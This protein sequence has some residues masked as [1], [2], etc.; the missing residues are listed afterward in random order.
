MSFLKAF[1]SPLKEFLFGQP[2]QKIKK[3][4]SHH[5]SKKSTTPK[6]VR[7][8][9]RLKVER[10]SRKILK[11]R[12]IKRKKDK[13][14]LL[15][16][17]QKE[18]KQEPPRIK[19]IL[20]GEITHYFSRIQVVVMKIKQGKLKLGDKLHIKGKVTDFS[21]DVKSM[22]IESVDVKEARKGQLIGLKV[23]KEAKVGD[24][25]FKV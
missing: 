13:R 23:N 3:Q 20:V 16:T 22:Q 19:E 5:R 18:R 24:H 25:V 11:S 4:K 12:L 14:A 8:K 21:Q 7:K 2:K 6:I 17:P 10:S 9:A 1:F 15:K